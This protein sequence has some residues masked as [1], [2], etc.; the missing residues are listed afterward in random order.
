MAPWEREGR[1]GRPL[2]ERFGFPI[3]MPIYLLNDRYVHTVLDRGSFFSLFNHF[4]AL[5]Q[6][7]RSVQTIDPFTQAYTKRGRKNRLRSSILKFRKF[8]QRTSLC[9]H[10][11]LLYSRG[12]QVVEEC[13]PSPVEA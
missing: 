1:P 3:P 9:R 10:D 12:T 4:P 11:T 13:K 2:E 7:G 6:V 5:S 8:S